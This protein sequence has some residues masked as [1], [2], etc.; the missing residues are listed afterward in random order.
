MPVDPIINLGAPVVQAY[1]A[2]VAMRQ[3]QQALNNDQMNEDRNFLF[4]TNQADINNRLNEQQFGLDQQRFSQSQKYNDALIG[5]MES[6]NA[7]QAAEFGQRLTAFD[8]N[9]QDEMAARQAYTRQALPQ[10]A[11]GLA[12]GQEQDPFGAMERV[13]QYANAPSDVTRPMAE[14]Q[15]KMDVEA[16]ARARVEA[17]MVRK[18]EAT[19]Q[20]IAQDPHLNETQ[21]QAAIASVLAKRMGAS[22]PAGAFR[23][24]TI[25]DPEAAA[26]SIY[27]TYGVQQGQN[28]QVDYQA[29]MAAQFAMQGRQP[30]T[31]A[32]TQGNRTT[33]LA[34]LPETAALQQ[35][36]TAVNLA[37][38]SEQNAEQDYNSISWKGQEDPEVAAAYARVLELRKATTE[39]MNALPQAYAA[40]RAA[41]ANA[42]PGVRGPQPLTPAAA[43]Q[44]QNAPPPIDYD[45]LREEAIKRLPPDATPEQIAEEMRL[46]YE[47]Q[48]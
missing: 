26:Q 29:R 39:A 30:P 48:P 41:Y 21:K 3:R 31:S 33:P 19:I 7:R 35:A 36:Q 2:G 46:I 4:R 38:F 14:A 11:P 32:Y 37:K 20:A 44:A 15:M 13:Q 10:I 1:L 5:N 25:M 27:D 17:E 42:N 23:Q 22:V 6:D 28:A 9:R 16:Q 8:L 45:A 40:R 34:S 12:T 47:N 24:S 18:S 43:P